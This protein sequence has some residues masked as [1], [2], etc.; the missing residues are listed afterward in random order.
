MALS[1]EELAKM[2]SGTIAAYDPAAVAQALF[3]TMERLS[4]NGGDITLVDPSNPFVLALTNQAI[5]ASV[6]MEQASDLNRM[7]YPYMARNQSELYHHMSDKDYYGRFANPS[8]VTCVFRCQVDDLMQVMVEVPELNQYKV[9]IPRNS[10]LTV[11]SMEFTMLYPIVIRRQRFGKFSV[12]YDTDLNSPLADLETNLIKFDTIRSGGVDWF[13]FEFE[14][15][16][17]SITSKRDTITPAAD[18]YLNVAFPRCVS[19][20]PRA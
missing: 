8:R 17:C 20:V 3:A 13:T 4:I 10:F 12:T 7:Q 5:M 11:D 1:I 6:M 15:M 18:T 14:L 19:T 2:H 9:V 16:Q